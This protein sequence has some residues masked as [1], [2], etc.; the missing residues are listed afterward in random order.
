MS[1]IDQREMPELNAEW[2][3]FDSR[4]QPKQV[5]ASE[6][7]LEAKRRE[8]SRQ[9]LQRNTAYLSQFDTRLADLVEVRGSTVRARD[10]EDIRIRIYDSNRPKNR[11]IV[12]FF[13]GGG[14][15]GWDL[16]TEDLSCRRMAID[17]ATVVVSV[18]YR[19][20]PEN[21]YPIPINDAWD[22]FLHIA[23]NPTTFIPRYAGS[24]DI[25]IAGTSS[26]AQL[27]SIVSQLAVKHLQ[28]QE[29]QTWKVCG[30]ILRTP[31]TV[32]AAEERYIPPQFRS[33][34][35]SW[36]P[37]LEYPG[38]L[39]REDMKDNHDLYGVPSDEKRSP[40]AY[41]LW[42]NLTGLPPTFVQIC[43]LDILRDDAICYVRG[44]TDAGVDVQS[45]KYEGLPHV[46]W[47]YAPQLEVSR[48]IEQDCV[49]GLNWIISKWQSEVS[50]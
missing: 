7:G 16:D 11:P 27:A 47:V 6:V 15:T 4:E 21:P 48:I 22:S 14:L 20:A 12:V 9:T 2:L 30:V 44:L 31:V 29:T 36:V 19:L 23:E 5:T 3:E 43:G 37:E 34:H 49:D 40:L 50:T 26:G 18:A 41:P 46:F 1:Q 17:G 33:L 8:H 28:E 10:G 24:A 25:V 38:R 35:Q 42:G 13:H 45:K 39:T 32:Y